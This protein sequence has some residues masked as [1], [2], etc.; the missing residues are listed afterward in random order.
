MG[1]II[2]I[3]ENDSFTVEFDK[4]FGGHDGYFKLGKNG[5]CW[6]FNVLHKDCF[7]LIS[8][9]EP[10][11]RDT[12]FKVGEWVRIRDWDDMKQEYDVVCGDIHPKNGVIFNGGKM[13]ELCGMYVKIKEIYGK[14]I[15]FDMNSVSKENLDWNWMYEKYMIE[16]LPELKVGDKV[17]FRTVEELSKNF[18]VAKNGD[19][20]TSDL[21]MLK[22]KGG[23]SMQ[24]VCGKE[25]I[26]KKVDNLSAGYQYIQVDDGYGFDYNNLMVEKVN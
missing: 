11:Q 25:Y 15:C 23:I 6:N 4:N 1:T 8:D 3:R 16:K 22:G 17:R 7:E 10:K 21:H 2:G 5:H 12:D 20:H 14:V 13:K 24:A 19:I 9:D 18:Y 26:V